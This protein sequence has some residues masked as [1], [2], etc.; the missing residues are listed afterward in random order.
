MIEMTAIHLSAL[1]NKILK[2]QHEAHICL[3]QSLMIIVESL[4]ISKPFDD[5]SLACMTSEHWLHT[6]EYNAT[7]LDLYVS[8][9]LT[10]MSISFIQILSSVWDVFILGVGW[11]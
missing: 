7:L 4:M 11:H 2:L 9:C 6:T 3:V 1:L 10:Y 8:F 5:L